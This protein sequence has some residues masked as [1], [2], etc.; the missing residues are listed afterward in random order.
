M[1]ETVD[2]PALRDWL[3]GTRGLGILAPAFFIR[4]GFP[5]SFV[6]KLDR[7]HQ[8]GPGKEAIAHE[9]RVVT[10]ADGVYELE[11]LRVLA[12]ELGLSVEEARGRQ[13]T[14]ELYANAILDAVSG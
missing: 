4:M 1:L 5:K 12:D 13:R 7:V 8:S 6:E 3:N 2:K 14:A 9:G 10:S 11:F